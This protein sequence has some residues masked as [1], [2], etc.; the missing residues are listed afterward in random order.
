VLR[1]VGGV[2][3]VR[4]HRAEPHLLGDDSA[5]K[6]FGWCEPLPNGSIRLYQ[7][8]AGNIPVY[9]SQTRGRVFA[10]MTPLEVS[11]QCTSE[12]EFDP[13]SVAEFLLH[14][15][16]CF[17]HTLFRNVYVAPPGA[18]T[19]VAPEAITSE[20]FYLPVE[21]D[22]EMGLEDHAKRLREEVRR[23][24]AVDLRNRKEIVVLFSGGQDAR[25]V[26][27]LIDQETPLRLIA[28]AASDNR[29]M[30]LARRAAQA[31]GRDFVHCRRPKDFY[32]ADLERRV[33]AMGGLDVARTHAWWPLSEQLRTADAVVGG[34]GCDALV[35][36]MHMRDV[37]RLRYAPE[38]YRIAASRFPGGVPRASSQGWLQ[39]SIAAAVEERQM[40]HLERLRAFRL[41]T[42]Q[43][44]F[45]LWP[46]G[47]HAP[48]NPQYLTVR[49]LN[50][51][52]VEP[53]IAP[54]VYRLLAA[55][56]DRLRVDQ[57]LFRTAF[58]KSMG[59]AVWLLS[60]SGRIPRLG[61]YPGQ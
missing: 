48:A 17:P 9:Y 37:V 59:R 4:G 46:R 35:K 31:L 39:R 6:P 56:P 49:M 61:G 52:V 43:N 26:V 7:D 57:R 5:T 38:R 45:R 12:P 32:A 54:S 53:F 27:G 10:G 25:A 11:R 19:I 29:E 21:G 41:T 8:E 42:A 44:W 34:Y 40:A 58:S 15:T 51:N 14:G 24:L 23:I 20:R 33:E 55:V 47:S 13:V 1:P 18:V 3:R 22:E 16:V 30:R 28:F 36:G 2:K 60:S 50:D